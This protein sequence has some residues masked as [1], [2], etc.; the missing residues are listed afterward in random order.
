[1]FTNPWALI[2]GGLAAGLPVAV[3]CLTRPKPRR[4]PMS[5]IRFLQDVVR[6][7]RARHRLRDILILTLRTAALLLLA[8]AIARPLWG[9]RETA[10][11]EESTA[12]AQ[13]VILDVSQSMSAQAGGSSTFE[14]ARAVASKL[15]EYRAGVKTNLILAG[16]RPR[17]VFA[18]PSANFAAL[19]DELATATAT[20][21]EL[22]VQLALVLAAENLAQTGEAETRRELVVVSDFQ[23]GNWA[24]ADFSSLPAGTAIKLESVAPPE[25][26]PNLAVV[27]VA[28][29]GRAET[30]REV[31][32][33]VQVGNYSATPRQVR[34]EA[35]LG[36]AVYQLSGSCPPNAKSTLTTSILPDQT[37]WQHGTARLVDVEDA[38][39]ADNSRPWLLQVQASPVYALLTRQSEAKRPSSSYYLQ[40]GLAPAES[41]NS[42]RQRVVRVDPEVLDRDALG[43]AELIVI[44]HP[45]RL[46]NE[47][48]NELAGLLR[49]GRG[50][51]YAAS[52]PIDASNIKLLVEAVG[53]GMQLPV[54]Y[55]PAPAAQPRKNLQLAVPRGDAVPWTIFGDQLATAVKPLRFSGG[56]SSRRVP[57]TLDDDV[58]ATFGDRSAFLA[59][60]S[61]DAGTLVVLN[62]DLGE[63]NLHQSPIYVP[64]LGELVQ[65]LL[66]ARGRRSSATVCGE[67]FV[68]ELPL[69]A[70]TAAGL[71]IVG[72]ST[73]AD[74]LGKLAQE[75]AGVRWTSNAAGPPGVYR[76]ER[77]GNAVFAM[78]AAISA[79]ESDLQS[80][81]ESVFTDRLAKG[82][83]VRYRSATIGEQKERDTIWTWLGVACVLCVVGEVVV[84]RFC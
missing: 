48:I 29:R 4:L 68:A 51:L 81:P 20:A 82:R 24:V 49:R 8:F 43:P 23:R 74:D 25:T 62:A 52:E 31:Q 75:S 54:D 10:V 19:R 76:V 65:R 13:V 38:M 32:L 71:K 79:E 34:V 18:G 45:G 60:A 33:E 11:P 28:T 42:K 63:S 30:G 37:G 61:A 1:M 59:M 80:L 2:L 44:D 6:Q 15:L 57:D 12:V 58:L 83:D 39:P 27:G 72:P 40:R 17:A 84:L 36:D 67:P 41:E 69:S 50:I 56:L 14:R 5:T 9:K 64:L 35:S 78:A 21:E 55:L 47:A 66:L 26:R 53:S 7:R 70:G 22:Q 46:S 73:V 16:A 77:N 3:H